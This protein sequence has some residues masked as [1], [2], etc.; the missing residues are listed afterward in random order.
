MRTVSTTG[1]EGRA[2]RGGL[3]IAMANNI[4]TVHHLTDAL[5]NRMSLEVGVHMDGIAGKGS[6][7]A[8]VRSVLKHPERVRTHPD[9]AKLTPNLIPDEGWRGGAT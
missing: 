4:L 3:A 7:L 1:D 9:D 2:M 6:S 5:E 8:R